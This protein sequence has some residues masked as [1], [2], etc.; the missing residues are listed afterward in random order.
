M[1]TN[2]ERIKSYHVI[3]GHSARLIDELAMAALTGIMA[4]SLN[5]NGNPPWKEAYDIAE[6]MMEEREKRMGMS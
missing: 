3:G 1:K 6:S 5:L 2:K 4:R